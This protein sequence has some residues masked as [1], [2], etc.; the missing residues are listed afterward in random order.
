MCFKHVLNLMFTKCIF[1]KKKGNSW[2]IKKFLFVHFS[3][4]HHYVNSSRR[5]NA[6]KPLVHAVTS[7]CTSYFYVF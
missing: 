7:N 3:M 6:E 1:N 2:V 4:M 5:K